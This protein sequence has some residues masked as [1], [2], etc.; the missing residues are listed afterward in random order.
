[1]EAPAPQRVVEGQSIASSEGVAE[2]E[3]SQRSARI[4]RG[5]GLVEGARRSE[6]S[7]GRVQASEEQED[8]I[9]EA[10]TESM[11]GIGG[12]V[13]GLME[14]VQ[15]E[16]WKAVGPGPNILTDQTVM[17]DR[18]NQTK[19]SWQRRYAGNNRNGSRKS[20]RLYTRSRRR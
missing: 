2:S 4:M 14:R 7:S 19:Q 17:N 5:R 11:A 3:G 20:H 15:W 8:R 12:V 6:S 16:T 1:M 13:A 9:T 18:E 10:I